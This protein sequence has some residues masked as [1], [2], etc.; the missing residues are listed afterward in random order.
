[1]FIAGNNYSFVFDLLSCNVIIPEDVRAVNPFRVQVS[2]RVE[3]ATSYK[4]VCWKEINNGKESTV[5]VERGKKEAG[6]G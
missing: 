6:G 4:T 3:S 1:M 5:F 2:E